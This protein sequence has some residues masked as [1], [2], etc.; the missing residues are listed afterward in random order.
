M[1]D[2][3]LKAIINNPYAGL[4]DF[5]VG[6]IVV[7][8]NTIPGI[9]ARIPIGAVGRVDHVIPSDDRIRVVTL[10][11]NTTITNPSCFRH[12]TVDEVNAYER[13]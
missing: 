12:A 2:A 5:R 7:R 6:D 11:G 3:E 10:G 8:V 13:S 4:T 9:P 1:N